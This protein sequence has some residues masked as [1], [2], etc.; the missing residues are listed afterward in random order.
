MNSIFL[1]FPSSLPVRPFISSLDFLPSPLFFFSNFVISVMYLPC[2]WT[3]VPRVV[4]QSWILE[5]S[6]SYYVP[7]PTPIFY[8]LSHFCTPTHQPYCMNFPFRSA[9]VSESV[10]YPF[11]VHSSPPF[12]Y[13]THPLSS[14]FEFCAARISF[15]LPSFF[16]CFSILFFDRSF[17][18]LFRLFFA[19]ARFLYTSLLFLSVLQCSGL[20][21]LH[22]TLYSFFSFE[23]EYEYE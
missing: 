18:P 12:F 3:F 7:I 1:F 16:L 10:L 8:L 2:L 14:H 19:A 9:L 13:T 6:H 21:F 15:L 5:P 17:I 20:D 11:N 22:A 4:S 23:I